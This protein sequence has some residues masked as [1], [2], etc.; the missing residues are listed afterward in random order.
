MSKQLEMVSLEEL[1]PQ[2][3]IYRRFEELF[4]FE[5]IKHRLRS[6]EKE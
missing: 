5:K 2:D 1:V 3:N 6:V 4:D